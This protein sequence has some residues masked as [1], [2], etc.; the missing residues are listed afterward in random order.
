MLLFSAKWIFPNKIQ[1]RIG[2]SAKWNRFERLCFVWSCNCDWIS[3]HLE[4]TAIAKTEY[5]RYKDCW[6]CKFLL[7]LYSISDNS[8]NDNYIQLQVPKLK[9]I[10]ETHLS[11]TLSKWNVVDHLVDADAFNA[12]KLKMACFEYINK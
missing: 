11:S 5:Q 1:Q 9:A 8:F 6:F 10:C 3:L 12:N 2:R 7:I 4:I